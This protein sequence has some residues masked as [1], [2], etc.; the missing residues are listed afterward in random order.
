[1]SIHSITV[2]YCALAVFV[3]IVDDVH[4]TTNQC[5]DNVSACQFIMNYTTHSN[6]KMLPLNVTRSF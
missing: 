5:N 2:H 4:K 6:V 1:M 3:K